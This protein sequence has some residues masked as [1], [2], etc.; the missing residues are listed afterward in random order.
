[1]FSIEQIRKIE[2]RRKILEESQ[3]SKEEKIRGLEEKIIE[4]NKF[5]LE[6]EKRKI[7]N[8]R[9]SGLLKEINQELRDIEETCDDI[10]DEIRRINRSNPTIDDVF[11]CFRDTIQKLLSILLVIIDDYI[12]T[13]VLDSSD[14]ITVVDILMEQTAQYPQEWSKLVG[15][16]FQFPRDDDDDDGDGYWFFTKR[17]PILEAKKK[18]KKEKVKQYIDDI[19]S[20]LH[21]IFFQDDKKRPEFLSDFG[22]FLTLAIT[23]CDESG[24]ILNTDT[25]SDFLSVSHCD[26][27]DIFLEQPRFQI[28]FF[29]AL[30]HPIIQEHLKNIFIPERKHR[31]FDSFLR[32]IEKIQ[33]FLCDVEADYINIK[34]FPEIVSCLKQI[35]DILDV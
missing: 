29:K 15:M 34:D 6:L 10:E 33:S 24:C 22:I 18:E 11:E 13:I 26:I 17:D 32:N 2:G 30:D 23:N 5:E 3:P 16:L 9:S 19:L 20:Q 1:M 4:L 35:C 27:R 31:S 28:I 25:A 14:E 21:R 8:S 12:R 7:E